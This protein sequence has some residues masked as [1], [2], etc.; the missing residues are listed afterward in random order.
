MHRQQSTTSLNTIS[1]FGQNFEAQVNSNM[2][3]DTQQ[4][5]SQDHK[6]KM[7]ARSP[8]PSMA[9]DGEYNE[10]MAMKDGGQHQLPPRF[11][12]IFDTKL[13]T[14][15][16]KA[17]ESYPQQPTRR[18]GIY[19]PKAVFWA[20]LIIFLFETAA[21]FAY[22]V[23]G[24]VSNMPSRLVPYTGASAVMSGCD[25]SAQQPIN[26]SPNFFMPQ[27]PQA[28]VVQSPTS[29][30]STT[31]STSTSSSTTSTSSSSSAE[32]VN[33]SQLADMI[34]SV[35]MIKA[36]S[37]STHSPTTKTTVVTP[38][39][40][41]VQST[42]LL[43]VDASG[44]PVEPRPTVT[45]TKVIDASE[46]SA[47]LT[48]RDEPTSVST[49]SPDTTSAAETPKIVPITTNAGSGGIVVSVSM[50]PVAESSVTPV[51][52]TDNESIIIT[53]SLKQQADTPTQQPEPAAESTEA[54]SSEDSVSIPPAPSGCE[55]VWMKSGKLMGVKCT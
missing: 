20:L 31:T 1:S 15:P 54:P 18:S 2:D 30:P 16:T 29:T 7:P 33:A 48:T 36:S 17:F 13:P 26:I 40:S 38:P 49:S 55:N 52:S 9:E 51:T 39:G 4:S 28:S 24:L 41:T 45:S 3:Q 44:K 23:I 46:A 50:A 34:K 43:T 32:G 10:K 12:A 35:G 14:T 42:K 19:V 37:S 53:A 5:A 22:T 21:L 6:G 11:S 27:A 8:S 25:C 47:S